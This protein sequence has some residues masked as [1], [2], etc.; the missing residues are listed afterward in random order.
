MTRAGRELVWKFLVPCC[1]FHGAKAPTRP[2]E[3]WPERGARHW[4][5]HRVPVPGLIYFCVE[6]NHLPPCHGLAGA[7]INNRCNCYAQCQ[8]LGLALYSVMPNSMFCS[9]CRKSSQGHDSKVDPD[10]PRHASRQCFCELR[11]KAW[12]CILLAGFDSASAILSEV[13]GNLSLSRRNLRCSRFSAC[14]R[15]LGRQALNRDIYHFVACGSSTLTV[16]V[17][18][19]ML[20]PAD[21]W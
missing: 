6:A 19:H 21:L 16:E 18:G 12:S 1:F 10:D 17:A 4:Q 15:M 14:F 20:T 2:F 5:N 3:V 7:P 13:A 8:R 11:S 9:A